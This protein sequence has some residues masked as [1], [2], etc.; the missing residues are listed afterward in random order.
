ML[1]D[2]MLFLPGSSLPSLSSVCTKPLAFCQNHGC[3]FSVVVFKVSNL[4][5]ISVFSSFFCPLSSV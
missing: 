1:K 2:I 3:N 5:V 4:D